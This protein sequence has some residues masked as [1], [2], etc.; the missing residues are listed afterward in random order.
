MKGNFHV[1]CWHLQ[2]Q[3]VKN[4]ILGGLNCTFLVMVVIISLSIGC[5]LK[6]MS[7][8]NME[9]REYSVSVF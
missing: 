6:E 7:T 2:T 5:Y 3:I 1:Y 8:I 9:T 4:R